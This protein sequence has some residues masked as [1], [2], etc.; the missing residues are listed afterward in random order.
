MCNFSRVSPGITRYVIIGI[1]AFFVLRS[2]ASGF[3]ADPVQ[4]GL[5]L[6]TFDIDATPPIGS[7][8]TY[9]REINK[10][11]LGLRAKGVVILGSGQPIV[12]CAVD[13]IGI[14]NEGQDAFRQELA[15]AAG[16]IPSRV[17]IHT[18]HQHDAPTCDF[19]AEKLLKDAGIDPMCYE[20]T[21]ARELIARLKIAVKQSLGHTQSI[22]HIG[23][24]EAEVFK[25]ASNR[26]IIGKDGLLRATRYSNCKDPALI[27]EPEGTIDPKVSLV[28]FW[29]ND[30]PVAVLSYYATHPQSYYHTAVANPDFPGVARFMRQLA[31]PQALHI[32]FNGAGGNVTAGKYNDESPENRGILG[33]RMADGMKRAWESTRREAITPEAIGWTVEPLALPLPKNEEEMQTWLTTKD[34]TFLSNNLSRLVFVRRSQAGKQLDI[35][36]LRLGRARILFAPGEMF[37]EYQLA[38][39]AFRPDLFVAMAAYGDYAPGYICT[40]VAYKEG[41]YES[42]IASGVTDEAEAIVMTAIRKLLQGNQ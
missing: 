29:N 30:K 13:W 17:A 31:V 26:R 7:L 39:K 34:S 38:A 14:A 41:G 35:R 10:W 37:V 20:S 8:L 3:P 9:N 25:V 32:H 12:L 42:G 2:G 5:Q 28:S 40:A 1:F 22:S 19:G 21:F 11:D 33:G 36:C 27:A 24:G 16:T 4:P 23:L 6:S 15:E 18:V